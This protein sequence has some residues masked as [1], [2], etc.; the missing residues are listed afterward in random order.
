MLVRQRWRTGPRLTPKLGAA[1][2]YLKTDD[3]LVSLV[4]LIS[5]RMPGQKTSPHMCVCKGQSL[6]VLTELMLCANMM[7]ALASCF[8]SGR[9]S[10]ASSYSPVWALG[11]QG[12]LMQL[13]PWHLLNSLLPVT[14]AEH[15]EHIMGEFQRI[16]L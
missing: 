13:P 9:N 14:A 6:E 1:D 11:L 3:F 10:Q 4:P 12:L 8:V 16:R 7:D 15:L 2:F 5:L